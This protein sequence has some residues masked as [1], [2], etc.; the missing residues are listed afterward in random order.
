[1][2]ESEITRHGFICAAKIFL[3]TAENAQL[4]GHP[5]GDGDSQSGSTKDDEIII[6]EVAILE[7]PESVPPS[8]VETYCSPI[9]GNRQI[10]SVQSHG[11][12]ARVGGISVTSGGGPRETRNAWKCCQTVRNVEV[13]ESDLNIPSVEMDS[14][15]SLKL[16]C[17]SAG[18]EARKLDQG[19]PN[20]SQMNTIPRF[21][22]ITA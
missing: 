7:I 10:L 15:I 18:M 6:I 9:L 21:R 20:L 3:V 5:V 4:H 1:V 13:V 14:I 19:T 17:G 22:G 16:L 8:C 12:A 2:P 11:C